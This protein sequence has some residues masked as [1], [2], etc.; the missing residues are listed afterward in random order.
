MAETTT[1]DDA[2]TPQHEA[3]TSRFRGGVSAR[4][5]AQIAVFA[6][7]IGAFGLVGS[8]NIAGGVPIT[9][10]TLGV[11]LAGSVLGPWRGLG[12][13][14]LLELAVTLG[15]PLL[16]GGRGGIG[17]F[18][19]PTVGYLIGWLAGVV[20][21]GLIVHGASSWRTGLRITWWKVALGSIVG[22]ILVIYAFGIPGQAL[23]TGL[24]MLE[25]AYTSLVFLPGDL[26]KVVLTVLI[27]MGLWRAYPKAF[28]A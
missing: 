22:G 20:V 13:V 23:M 16:A 8:I 6:A 19:T 14:A 4:A 3:R 11:M 2:R 25:T 17:V 21:I 27:T 7:L 28:R 24:S 26:T 5:L 9:L 12:A 1:P 18:A 15:L 10:Q